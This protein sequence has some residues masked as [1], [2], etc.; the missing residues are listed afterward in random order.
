MTYSGPLTRYAKLRVAHAP[1]MPGTFSR[2]RKLLVSDPGTHH[3]TCLTHVPWCMSGS[4]TRCCRENVPGIPGA[5]ATRNFKYLVRGPWSVTFS[6]SALEETLDCYTEV[7]RDC[8]DEELDAYD[9][10]ESYQNARTSLEMSCGYKWNLGVR[11]NVKTIFPFQWKSLQF[12]S[13]KKSC[14]S[15]QEKNMILCELS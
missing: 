10:L 2:H 9:L 5:C 1:G 14:L 11:F 6:F 7:F 15:R 4:L 13:L 3:G 8:T 12:V